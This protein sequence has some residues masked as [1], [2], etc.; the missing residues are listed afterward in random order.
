MNL[1]RLSAN[2]QITVPAEIRK[3]LK[4]K[5]GDKVLLYQN[6][7]GEIVLGNATANAL[8]RV[9]NAMDGVAERLGVHDEDDVQLL[10]N[11]VRYNKGEA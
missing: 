9:Q 4:L 5:P 11:E 10:V 2:G 8:F 7:S 6:E 3:L 1:V